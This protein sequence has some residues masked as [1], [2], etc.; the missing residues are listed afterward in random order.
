M[1]AI[2]VLGD[3][4]RYVGQDVDEGALKRGYVELGRKPNSVQQTEQLQPTPS[5]A[6]YFVCLHDG[7]EDGM[8]VFRERRRSTPPHR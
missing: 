1:K 4:T 3:G 6:P 2:I 8:P 5:K 7:S